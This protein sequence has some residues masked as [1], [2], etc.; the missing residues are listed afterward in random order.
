MLLALQG[1][2]RGLDEAARVR[3]LLA[4]VELAGRPERVEERPP[5]DPGLV[6]VR[7]PAGQIVEGGLHR[8]VAGLLEVAHGDAEAAFL[9]RGVGGSAVGHE[10]GVVVEDH[11]ARHPEGVEIRC[12]AKADSLIPLARLTTRERRK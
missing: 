5:A 4:V 11:R 3:E 12:L 6:E 1:P 2:L 8:A 7:V 10:A 9:A